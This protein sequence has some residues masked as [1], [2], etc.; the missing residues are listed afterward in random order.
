M[1]LIEYRAALDA[2][3]GF[4][5]DLFPAS[6]DALLRRLGAALVA[7]KN[8]RTDPLFADFASLLANVIRTRI[9]Q[10]R[11]LLP[12]P[13]IDPLIERITIGNSNIPSD[14]LAACHFEVIN[15]TDNAIEVL[16]GE[17]SPEWIPFQPAR[18]LI[19]PVLLKESRRPDESC[20]PDPFLKTLGRGHYLSPALREAMRAVVTAPKGSTLLV[21]YPTGSGKSLL[22]Q[23]PALLSPGSLS[24][25]IVPTIA[26]C[27]DQER[28]LG[29]YCGSNRVTHDTAFYGSSA[30]MVDRKKA[31]LKRIRE[32]TQRVVFASP[33]AVFGQSFAAA[34][35][36][37]A[38]A[39]AGRGKLEWFVIDEA[40]IVEHWGN[41]FRPAFQQLTGLRR[42]LLRASG[43]D[44]F[45]TLLMSATL[46]S[47][48]IDTL[49]SRFGGPRQVECINAVRIRPEISS[50]FVKCGSEDL[51]I[52]RTMDAILNLPKPLI[53]Y[54]TRV[55]D[56]VDIHNRLVEMGLLRVALFTGSTGDQERANIVQGFRDKDVDIVVATSA[57]GMG[58]DADV[59]SVLHSCVPESFDRYYQEIGRGGRDG[60]ACISLLIYSNESVN[61]A[62]GMALS[63][64]IG[65]DRG[66]VRWRR[67][68]LEMALCENPD[69]FEVFV[70]RG[71]APNTRNEHW[72]EHTLNLLASAGVIRFDSTPPVCHQNDVDGAVEA[73][74]DRRVIRI[75]ENFPIADA[76][77]NRLVEP[78]RLARTKS[79]ERQFN[80]MTDCLNGTKC[81]AT[82]ATDA[83]SSADPLARIR[84]I[85]TCGGCKACQTGDPFVLASVLP[86]PGPL[87]N[88]KYEFNSL[89]PTLQSLFP[90]GG[91]KVRMVFFPHTE[92][93]DNLRGLRDIATWAIRVGI[94]F[95]VAPQVVLTVLDLPSGQDA[96]MGGSEWP[97]VGNV[98]VV[99]ALEVLTHGFVCQDE[100]LRSLDNP[101]A[102]RLILL[103]E[104]TKDSIGRTVYDLGLFS[105]SRVRE[106][107]G[108]Y[109]IGDA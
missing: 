57:F 91:S 12:D 92:W 96:V 19:A 46:T 56:A 26:L 49:K 87:Q 109:G 50:W 72:D 51:R 18:C 82:I 31:I 62:M 34:L 27:I 24:V 73:N 95:V 40:H 32:G 70:N 16:I 74:V 23:V 36:E 58:I 13:P 15:S 48:T 101:V 45:R 90:L 1:N 39:G 54:T 69:L 41:S 63:K 98:P 107:R 60:S 52:Q 29:E 81:V 88:G 86:L 78:I 77:W 67:M 93:R 10:R 108:T 38:S 68:H 65:R 30:E 79:S 22:A 84:I 9:A 85:A 64:T 37:S 3:R 6:S 17:W 42:G 66:L 80:L 25:V 76:T 44:P 104:S 75:L 2:I 102:P 106:F 55:A 14:I 35:W 28:A 21:N 7:A 99:P 61:T 83:Y 59:R 103:D 47:E 11:A 43:R 33:E 105:A 94:R 97:R 53:A 5:P 20:D 4:D 71:V 89:S 100:Y 8:N